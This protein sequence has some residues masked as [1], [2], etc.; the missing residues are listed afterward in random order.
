M[1]Y[2]ASDE[3]PNAFCSECRPRLGTAKTTALLD[4]PERIISINL[5]GDDFLL[6]WVVAK[7][8]CAGAESHFLA[9]V[10]DQYSSALD[11]GSFHHV[12][13]GGK[14]SGDT[15]R[16]LFFNARNYGVARDPFHSRFSRKESPLRT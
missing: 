11:D 12:A 1:V 10:R 7:I 9:C 15:V 13:A 8:V 5:P 3:V 2:R 4:S 16:R 6:Q 14:L